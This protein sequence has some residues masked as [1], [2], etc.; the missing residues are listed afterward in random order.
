MQMMADKRPEEK[1]F[2][3]LLLTSEQAA[4]ALGISIRY[5][6][7]LRQQGDIFGIKIGNKLLYSVDMLRAFANGESVER[8][9]K[10]S[11]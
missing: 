2:E 6:F 9:K 10:T 11:G 3:P 7:T 8:W 4:K 1:S 5:L